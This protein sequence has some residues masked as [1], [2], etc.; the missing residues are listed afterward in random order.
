MLQKKY[1]KHVRLEPNDIA[2]NNIDELFLKKCITIIEKNMA[3]QNFN[4]NIFS[5]EI[6]MSHSVL[7]RKI[8]A[9]T[10]ENVNAFIKTIRL[11]RAAQLILSKS[12]SIN[13][14]SDMTGFSN[15]KYFS[16]CFKNKYKKSPSDFLIE[17]I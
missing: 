4:I 13:Q 11:T 3:N 7:Y 5:K 2:I 6:G 17:N 9:L 15:P 16:T 8:K 10:G 12:Y 1:S 14:I